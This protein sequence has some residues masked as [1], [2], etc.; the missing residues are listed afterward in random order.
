MHKGVILLVKAEDR[1]EA[2]QK[3]DSFLES[4]QDDVWDW[5][6]LGG[7]WTG[8]LTGYKPEEDPRNL[9]TCRYCQGTGD[10]KDL[11]PPEWKKECGGC[12]SCHGKGQK[13]KFDLVKVD[14]DSLPCS[15]PRALAKIKEWGE[16]WREKTLQEAEKGIEEYAS[17][18]DSMLGY[19]LRKKADVLQDRFCFESDVYDTEELTHELPKNLDGYW[20][21]V[22]DM[23]N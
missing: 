16:P 10:R 14:D 3:A 17:K 2:K 7:R 15:D 9:E 21:V 12:N 23:H 19:F 13:V 5:Y 11:E 6:Q 18:S 1:E 20:A 8:L 22:A 4:Y